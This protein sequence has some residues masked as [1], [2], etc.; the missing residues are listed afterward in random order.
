T[1]IKDLQHRPSKWVVE[2]MRVATVAVGGLVVEEIPQIR[3]GN[4]RSELIDNRM[5]GTCHGSLDLWPIMR[6]E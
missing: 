6:S 1:Q 3:T 2:S 4:T 5:P